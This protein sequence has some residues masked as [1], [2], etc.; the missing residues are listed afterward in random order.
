MGYNE[1]RP[2]VR[3]AVGLTAVDRA[4]VPTARELTSDRARFWLL[5][6][7]NTRGVVLCMGVDR[8]DASSAGHAVRQVGAGKQ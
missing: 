4:G 3:Q 1:D 6:A 7:I 2:T 5:K 8:E